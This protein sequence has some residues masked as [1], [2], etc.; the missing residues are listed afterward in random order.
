MRML[1]K[2]LLAAAVLATTP[3]L[4]NA[5]SD[6]VSGTGSA[7]AQLD[8]Q[9]TIPRILFLR[10]GTGTDFADNATVDMI[11]FNVPGADLGNGTSVAATAASGDL[12]NGAVTARVLGNGG[13]VTLTSTTL[14]A[15]SNGAGSTISYSQIETAVTAL[16]GVGGVPMPHPALADTGT[17]SVALASTLG[18]VDRGATWTFSYANDNVVAPGTYGGAGVN[19]GRVTYTAATP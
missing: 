11:S 16:G 12:G 6:F 7:S 4:A 17:G 13:N 5:E 8:F 9:I 15:L 14:G 1:T 2:T 18:I 19:N 10:V 3:M